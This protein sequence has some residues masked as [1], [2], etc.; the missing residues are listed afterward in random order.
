V[1]P[2]VGHCGFCSQ[3]VFGKSL[4]KGN[5]YPS[6]CSAILRSHICLWIWDSSVRGILTYIQPIVC[7][8]GLYL[9]SGSHGVKRVRCGTDWLEPNALQTSLFHAQFCM[10]GP[11]PAVLSTPCVKPPLSCP[12]TGRPHCSPPSNCNLLCFFPH[13]IEHL[14]AQ[15][16]YLFAGLLLP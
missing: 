15:C 7:V 5:L 16:I 6:Y 4:Y 2:P 14:L 9:W 3:E 10:C 12:V 11:H 1:A 8:V 13:H